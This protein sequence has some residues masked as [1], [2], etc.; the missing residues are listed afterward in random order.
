M[1]DYR[2]FKISVNGRI[3]RWTEAA[4]KRGDKV[5]ATARELTGI[6]DLKERFGD[7]VLPLALNVTDADQA[8]HAALNTNESVRSN[9]RFPNAAR[10]R[11]G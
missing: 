9:E 6:A 4:L 2:K 3:G 1:H 5:A 7:A 10:S 11:V 8:R